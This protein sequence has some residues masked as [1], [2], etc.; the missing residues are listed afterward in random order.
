VATGIV[1]LA[2]REKISKHL[3]SSFDPEQAFKHSQTQA[4]ERLFKHFRPESPPDIGVSFSKSYS[5]RE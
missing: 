1:P 3:I 2:K 4:L 5:P